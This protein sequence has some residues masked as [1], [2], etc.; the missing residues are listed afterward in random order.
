MWYFNIGFFERFT[1]T[2][3]T[4]IL[5]IYLTFRKQAAARY[6]GGFFA[7]LTVFNAGYL[8]G[9][10][11]WH[12]FAPF[13]FHLA[14]FITIA[15]VFKIQFAYRMPGLIFRKES[16]VVFF[17]T[18]AISILAI[19]DYSIKAVAAG[20]RF[21]F[22]QHIY[23]SK[24]ASSYIPLAS[25]VMFLWVAVVL[26]RQMDHLVLDA[27]A[28]RG[29]AF[30][31]MVF[32]P[33]RV[34]AKTIRAASPEAV[35]VRS[36]LVLVLVEL[37][38][39]IF[40]LLGFLTS[41][42][43]RKLM[44]QVLNI[45]LLFV[46]FSYGILYVNH[47][48]QSSTMMLRLVGISLV[49]LLVVIGLSG[50]RSLQRLE[51]S[52]DLAFTARLPL[53]VEKVTSEDPRAPGLSL[54][55]DLAYAAVRPPGGVHSNAYVVLAS[56]A[57]NIASE[58]LI[59]SDAEDRDFM[60]AARAVQIKRERRL[61]LEE[62]RLLAAAEVEMP[63]VF[64]GE[65]RFRTLRGRPYLHYDVLSG[66]QVY[67]FGFAY[68]AYR[69][70]I[71]L[72]V[73]ENMLIVLMATGGI[74]VIFPLFFRSSLVA[75]LGLL[76]AG[77]RRVNQGDF[78]SP[79]AVPV[80]D[81]I[82]FLARAFNAMVDSVRS[83]QKT[84]REYVDLLEVRVRERTQQLQSAF[85]NLDQLKKKQDGDY[86]L[87]SLLISPL[88]HNSIKGSAF[89]VEF[90]TLQKKQFEFK[91]WKSEIGGDICIGDQITLQGKRYTVVLNAD[92][93][94]KSIQGSG[95][96]LVLGS[97]F[98]AILNR[99]QAG[100]MA[101]HTPERWIQ[102][103][104][105]EMD[106]VFKSFKASMLVSVCL[107]LLDEETGL[108]YYI[109]AEHPLPVVIRDGRA[110]FLEYVHLLNK[111]GTPDGESVPPVET[112]QLLPDDV[113]LLGSDGR[114]DIM[115]AMPG[116]PQQMNEDPGL[117]LSFAQ[118]AGGQLP[119]IYQALSS[120]GEI[121]DDLSLARV[122]VGALPARQPRSAMRDAVRVRVAVEDWAGAAA[123]TNAFLRSYPE[124][125][126][127]LPTAARIF[128]KASVFSRAIDALE[129]YRIRRPA[130]E[131]A[132]LYDLAKLYFKAGK[133]TRAVQVLDE[134]VKRWPSDERALQIREVIARK[135]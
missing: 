111:L 37:A 10:S 92:A 42:V 44:N 75:P 14:C 71:H 135:V 4:L 70:P 78:S 76:L 5:A 121:T 86:F 17:L 30:R 36:F 58:D 26:L 79:V 74:L 40:V 2:V 20:N 134:H 38:I 85:D 118:A 81:E 46:Y 21:V 102:Q 97:L 68:A 28:W 99:T 73:V 107:V 66:G 7:F 1:P 64:P 89:S 126:D 59:Q 27:A 114:D 15:L 16:Y 103:G 132:V 22:E 55:S 3:L 65:R 93:M 106:L 109:C 131:P 127:F 33:F 61:S 52:F 49:T 100:L 91:H 43:P 69:S 119:Q 63:A 80:E 129:A 19:A 83:A 53:L 104:F 123:A 29:G 125:T 48:R 105:R 35:A 18:T 128:K 94:G 122:Q 67:E 51:S 32:W 25:T 110:S 45:G 24:H 95:G 90:F 23:A 12:P 87:T 41:I 117:F 133:P 34:V 9:F 39:N 31:R 47:S 82:G 112:F 6:L 77:V 130:P 56:G 98:Q 113:L 115:L 50:A 124:D 116:G 57:E 108:A 72:A 54:P 62:A 13:G 88:S 101:E 11:G 120:A 96:V 84:L 8:L 60:I